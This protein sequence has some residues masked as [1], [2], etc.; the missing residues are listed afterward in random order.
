MKVKYQSNFE[1]GRK[2]AKYTVCGSLIACIAGL[3]VFSGDPMM[4][5]VCMVASIGLMAATFMFIYKFCVCPYCGK[6]VFFGVLSVKSCP[7]C[8][9]NFETGKKTKR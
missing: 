8:R 1:Y 5:T 7:R 6:H 4:Q 2:M 9:K 3:I